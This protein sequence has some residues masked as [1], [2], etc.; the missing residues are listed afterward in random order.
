MVWPPPD[1]DE[2]SITVVDLERPG[3]GQTTGGPTGLHLT[4][5]AEVRQRHRDER[6]HEPLDARSIGAP[7]RSSVQLVAAAAIAVVAVGLGS[8]VAVRRANDVPPARVATIQEAAPPKGAGTQPNAPAE[9]AREATSSAARPKPSRPT[10]EARAS[11]AES[12]ARA[13]L[14]LER[15][16]LDPAFRLVMAELESDAP[17]RSAR[18]LLTRIL[19]EARGRAVNA[20]RAADRRTA[21]TSRQPQYLAA[22]ARGSAALSAWRAGRYD[23]ALELFTEA[24]TAFESIPAGAPDPS[25]TPSRR[26]ER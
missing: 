13:E 25:E 14:A 4:P 6:S 10:T 16:E 1:A 26:L 24:T 2:A 11:R 21:G 3:A 17:A 23:V 9:R 18:D 7:P 8:Y 5:H 12:M 15:G 19:R 20:R 22:A